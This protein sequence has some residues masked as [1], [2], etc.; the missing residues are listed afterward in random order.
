VVT[1]GVQSFFPA[2]GPGDAGEC[3]AMK[4]FNLSNGRL[5]IARSSGN[6]MLLFVVA[7][8]LSYVELG[9][10]EDPSFSIKTMLVE[11]RWPGAT[12]DD[13]M[14]AE[15]RPDLK[16]TAGDALAYYLKSQTKPGVSHQSMSMFST[17]RQKRHTGYLVPGAQE[18]RRHQRDIAARGRR[19]LLSHDGVRRRLAL[20]TRSPPRFFSPPAGGATMSRNIRTEI[21]T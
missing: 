14:L 5:I 21:L 16:E 13:T 9:R 4:G 10:E 12:I 15:H 6:L 18:G 19:T 3:R 11:T 17:T 2:E 1:A 7:G 8:V 20:S